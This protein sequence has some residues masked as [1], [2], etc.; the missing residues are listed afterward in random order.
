MDTMIYN[1]A[2][3]FRVYASIIFL[4]PGVMRYAPNILINLIP[5]VLY[6][7]TPPSFSPGGDFGNTQCS[8]SKIGGEPDMTFKIQ[9]SLM[10]FSVI[11]MYSD[12]L[13]LSL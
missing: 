3:F 7:C 2:Y 8:N 11:T 4:E 9:S 13:Y 6:S 10:T 5:P 1:R 12:E